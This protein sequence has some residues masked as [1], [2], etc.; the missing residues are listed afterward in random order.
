M[1]SKNVRVAFIVGIKEYDAEE[2]KNLDKAVND[3]TAVA[4]KLEKFGFRIITGY[5]IT[6]YK[7]DELK[8]EYLSQLNDAKVGLFYFAGHGIEIDGENILLAKDS[9]VETRR[10]DTV[11]RTSIILQ[12]L[13]DDFHKICQANIFIVD[14]C[15]E[16]KNELTRGND[17]ANIAPIKAPQGTLIAFSTS[18]GEKAGEGKVETRN[19]NY[20]T[21]L[22]KHLEEPGVEIERFFKKV[23]IT[24]HHMTNGTQTSWEHT[25]LIGNLI[26]NPNTSSSNLDNPYGPTA[27]ADSKWGNPDIADLLDGFQSHNY[28]SQ[29][30]ALEAFKERTDYTPDQAFVL[31]R[32]ILQSA[33][34]GAW[35]CE[36]FLKSISS[37]KRYN[38]LEGNNHVLNGIL[39]EIYFDNNGQFRGHNLK[40]DD[41]YWLTKVIRDGRFA[42]SLEFISNQLRPYSSRLL[43]VPSPD[44]KTIEINVYGKNVYGK[45]VSD[46]LSFEEYRI[47]EILVNDQPIL[48]EN[49]ADAHPK[50]MFFRK[51]TV[52]NF[53]N[54]L[55]VQYGIPGDIIK[56]T[57]IED[58][59][60]KVSI[61]LERSL[62]II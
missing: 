57:Y 36:E 45:N 54:W 32:N 30:P 58:I 40:N 2:I 7:F 17:T 23:R 37:I 46:E 35:K 52:E 53:Q 25:S 27:I 26:L 51:D 31:G 43:Y 33:L 15:R 24:L 60:P 39:F 34:G 42:K 19:S 55:A 5:D 38:D 49:K 21:A 4:E 12:G 14:A 50:S 56:W 20:T 8:E 61:E 3:A 59:Q 9:Q 6:A 44:L 29:N 28:Y 62:K 10:L 13:I 47:S 22:L 11:K 41:L 18:P 1:E 48:T 16:V